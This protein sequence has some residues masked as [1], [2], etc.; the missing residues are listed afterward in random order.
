MATYRERFKASTKEFGEVDKKFDAQFEEME[1]LMG[2][3]D[4]GS[5]VGGYCNDYCV[6]HAKHLP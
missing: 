6:P 3:G 2:E 1:D 5:N 4:G